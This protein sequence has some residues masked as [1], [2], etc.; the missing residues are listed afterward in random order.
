LNTF[1]WN[2]PIVT[3]LAYSLLA[4]SGTST[5]VWAQEQYPKAVQI[6]APD[7]LSAKVY[8]EPS[9]TSEILDQA[10]NGAIHEVV[11]ARND[12]IEINLPDAGITGFVLKSNTRPWSA[13]IKKGLS[14]TVIALIA[15]FLAILAVAGIVVFFTRFRKAKAAE[16][17]AASIPAAIKMAEEC[18]RGGDYSRALR[19]FTR[20][21]DMQGGE[22]RN[23]DVYRRMSVCYQKVGE[24]REAARAWEKM[25]SLGGLRDM[26]DHSLGVALMMA[27][28]KESEAAL[29]Y[30]ELL[31]DEKD[32]ET[33]LEIH[34]K[35]FE[36]YRRLKEPS[37][38]M[39]HAEVLIESES[40]EETV[41][42]DTVSFFVTEGQ[43]DLAVHSG[44]E[45]L[46]KGICDEFMEMKAKTPEATRI[47]LKNTR[48]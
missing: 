7:G 46:V 34:T 1:S 5:L 23:P 14:K 21:V 31:Q 16:V 24:Y 33:R 29:I 19:E 20:Y 25:R 35:L 11:G 32:E 17:R 40:G 9:E 44:N 12:F 13:P 15:V 37:K 47:Y 8:S 4:L 18:F 26:E 10:F 38:L 43:T 30:E 41:L 27:L 45:A 42:N 22:V 48:I 36:T 2:R 39:R 28:G 3:I 6:V